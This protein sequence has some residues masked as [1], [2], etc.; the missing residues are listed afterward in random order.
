MKI[1]MKSIA[2]EITIFIAT[3][4][5]VYLIIGVFFKATPVFADATEYEVNVYAQIGG[6]AASSPTSLG[7]KLEGTYVELSQNL[8]IQTSDGTKTYLLKG[9]ENLTSGATDGLPKYTYRNVNT[10]EGKAILGF[11]MP[12]RNVNIKAVYEEAT[13]YGNNTSNNLRRSNDDESLIGSLW[14]VSNIYMPVEGITLSTLTS[15][16]SSYVKDGVGDSIVYSANPFLSSGS[17][18]NKTITLDAGSAGTETV[19]KRAGDLVVYA[20]PYAKN[21]HYIDDS[22]ITIAKSSGSFTFIENAAAYTGDNTFFLTRYA[23][24]SAHNRY[25]LLIFTMP[26]EDVTIT[27]SYPTAIPVAQA[28]TQVEAPSEL[29]ATINSKGKLLVEF[30]DG[31]ASVI[32]DTD[33]IQ[34]NRTNILMLQD[35]LGDSERLYTYHVGNHIYFVTGSHTNINVCGSDDEKLAIIQAEK[36]GESFV[37]YNGSTITLVTGGNRTWQQVY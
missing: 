30:E 28:I 7:T 29:S 10:S 21:G 13:A 4:L 33:D 25:I 3:L 2:K 15:D 23:I 5:A 17:T 19:T 12:A 36:N 18:Y 14:Q 9:W 37:T 22:S 1:N 24:D 16:I 34:N 6:S 8:Q 26:D 11:Y 35:Q 20:V 31:R 27:A 32:I